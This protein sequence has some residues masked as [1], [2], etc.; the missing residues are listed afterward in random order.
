MASL[1]DSSTPNRNTG[2]TERGAIHGGDHLMAHYLY[3]YM[4]T[5]PIIIIMTYRNSQHACRIRLKEQPASRR[6]RTLTHIRLGGKHRATDR[7]AAK[8]S[9]LELLRLGDSCP[10]VMVAHSSASAI[11]VPTVPHS[12]PGPGSPGSVEAACQPSR[13][14]WWSHRA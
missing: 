7:P 11:G 10:S 5:S 3:D 9:R 2:R 13:A 12:R 6:A 4:T 14:P 8:A 1:T